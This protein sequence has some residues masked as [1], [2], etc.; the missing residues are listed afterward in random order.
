MMRSKRA[1]CAVAACMIALSM[2]FAEEGAPEI[3]AAPT[4]EV[5]SPTA[6]PTTEPTPAPTVEPT[7]EPTTEPTAAPTEAPTAAPTAAPTT[8]PTTTPTTEPTSEPTAE[9]TTAP[10]TAPTA[11]PA[12]TPA[13][14]EI[15]PEG[16]AQLVENVWRI[17]VASAEEEIRFRWTAIEGATVYA[18]QITDGN[19][20][21]VYTAQ[22]PAASAII[23]ANTLQINA[24]YTISV[25]AYANE[26]PLIAGEIDFILVLE[27]EK[28]D[29]VPNGGGFPSGGRFPSGGISGGAPSGEAQ[30]DMGFHVTAGEALT[31]RHASGTGDAQAY[32]TLKI[33]LSDAAETALSLDGTELSVTLNDGESGFCAAQ[34]GDRLI[35]TPETD[36]DAWHIN[37]LAL[38]TLRRSGI[39][40]LRLRINDAEIEISTNW[41]PCGAIYAGLSAAGYVSKDYELTV[42]ASEQIV[43]VAGQT[44]KFNENNELVGG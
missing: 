13:Q 26:A 18:V 29:D 20:N 8:E 17:S 43:T 22:E 11:E 32:G 10:T 7:V 41:Q 3:T 36:G 9:L 38:K 19:G 37:A 12:P 35:L 27:A 34:D 40:A 2:G 15:V 5:V 39:S 28:P 6:A 31:S 44:Y 21:I 23:P 42:T 30:A 16:S 1:L 33:V 4:A 24:A 25:S 14:F